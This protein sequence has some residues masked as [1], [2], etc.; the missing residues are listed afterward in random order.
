MRPDVALKSGQIV[1]A[2][3]A[4]VPIPWNSQEENAPIKEGVIPIEGKGPHNFA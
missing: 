3:F 4:I 1:D 2:N